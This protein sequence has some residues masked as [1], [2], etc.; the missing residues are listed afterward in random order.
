MKKKWGNLAEG[1]GIEPLA[2]GHPG[3]QDQLPT[4]QWHP[5]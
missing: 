5:L 3:F 2:N 4:I 1:E